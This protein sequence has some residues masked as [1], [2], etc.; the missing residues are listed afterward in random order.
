[1]ILFL[2]LQELFMK[3]SLILCLSFLTFTLHAAS[4]RAPRV[5]T[6]AVPREHAAFESGTAFLMQSNWRRAERELRRALRL[7]DSF[8]EAHNN[9]AFVLR[10]QGENHFEEALVHYRRALELKPDLAEAHMYLGVLYVQKGELDLAR[11]T[12]A[13]LV[14][15]DGTLAD[16]LDWVIEHGREKE[17]AQF[18]GVVR[19]L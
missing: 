15:L 12:Y 6:P 4:S 3:H 16:E 9:L 8:A 18:F 17:P 10:K 2:N 11:E 5:E 14:S 1:M 13:R 7:N 19:N